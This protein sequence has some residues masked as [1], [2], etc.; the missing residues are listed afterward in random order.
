MGMSAHKEVR[1]KFVNKLA[2][3][4]VVPSRVSSDM[5]HQYLETLALKEPMNGIS[6]AKV[7]VVAISGDS[8]QRLECSNFFRCLETA[9]EIPRMPDFVHRSE[10]L[11]ELLAEDPVGIR[12]ETYVLH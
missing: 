10:E 6:I 2:S 7:I 11:P 4:C 9:S 5:S 1:T 3:L 8:H 12:Y